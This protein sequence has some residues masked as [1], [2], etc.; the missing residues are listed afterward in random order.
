MYISPSLIKYSAS[1]P[2]ICVG[3][4]GALPV[5]PASSGGSRSE[6]PVAILQ[7]ANIS[8]SVT[9]R[10]LFVANAQRVDVNALVQTALSGII[11]DPQ[12]RSLY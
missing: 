5:A 8:C 9:S 12:V 7:V 3:V 2:K 1:K 10:S 4:R 11:M 6:Q